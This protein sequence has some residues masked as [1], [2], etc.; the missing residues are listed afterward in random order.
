MTDFTATLVSNEHGFDDFDISGLPH[1]RRAKVTHR[2][3]KDETFNVYCFESTK[4]GA[5]WAGSI[6]QSLA[7]FVATHPLYL[8]KLAEAES[9]P[10]GSTP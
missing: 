10:T 5:T 4:L 7:E 8:E 1:V 9:I 3:K 6:E 2:I